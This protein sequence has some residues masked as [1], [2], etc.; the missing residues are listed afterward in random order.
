MFK[1]LFL[2]VFIISSTISALAVPFSPDAS[3]TV[4]AQRNPGVSTLEANMLNLVDRS[5]QFKGAVAN[6][7]PGKPTPFQV[8]AVQS[9]GAALN[10]ALETAQQHIKAAGTLSDAD[11][12][13]VQK[14]FT[15]MKLHVV[16]AMKQMEPFARGEALEKL[17]ENTARLEGLD[18][19]T[20][21]SPIPNP[22][23]LLTAFL[24]S[25]DDLP[26]LGLG[27]LIPI[28][29]LPRPLAREL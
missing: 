11:N 18:L 15:D 23:E 4:L 22:V 13:V 10:K 19:P 20:D 7:T 5:K 26:G 29:Q 1:F 9:Q 21:G 28:H 27:D 2:G 25:F 8:L 12:L 14:G 6:L 16:S 24:N 17:R 3:N